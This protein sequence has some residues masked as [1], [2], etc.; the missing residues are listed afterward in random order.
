L[1]GR[2]EDGILRLPRDERKLI[3]KIR[4]NE[5]VRVEMAHN[6]SVEIRA[7]NT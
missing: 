1:I 3:L 4:E 2:Y 7:P 6:I 5:E